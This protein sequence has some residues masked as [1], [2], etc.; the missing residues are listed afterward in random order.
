MPVPQ[1]PPH[2]A[3][4]GPGVQVI[5]DSRNI[6]PGG[7]V[8]DH[9]YANYDGIAAED[10]DKMLYR[11]S[12]QK[13]FFPKTIAQGGI[14]NVQQHLWKL[15]VKIN[16]NSEWAYKG[17]TGNWHNYQTETH[18]EHGIQYTVI[19]NIDKVIKV[20]GFPRSTG[21]PREKILEIKN[22]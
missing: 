3:P 13:T 16:S 1:Q 7:H 12:D 6:Q 2:I 5:F 22:Q 18:D 14:G 9:I 17:M 8:K 19:L 21:T 20:S 10:E 15:A 4:G 11:T